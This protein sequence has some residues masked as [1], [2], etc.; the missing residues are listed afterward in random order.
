VDSGL[1]VNR[2]SKIIG[3]TAREINADLSKRMGRV[4]RTAQSRDDRPGAGEAIDWGRGLY[5]AAQREILEVLVNEPGLFHDRR[6]QISESLFD[7]PILRQ[8][9][10]LLLDVLR[11]DEDFSVSGVLARTESVALAE[12][13]VELQTVGE[14]KG[15]FASRLSD[16]LDVL[17]RRQQR[18]ETVRTDTAEKHRDSAEETEECPVRQNPHSIGML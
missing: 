16:A 6:A 13:L 15:N 8:A 18:S 14:E 7:V 9:A 11:S 2:L 17:C 12:C 5:A 1:I 4:A 10:G 3:L